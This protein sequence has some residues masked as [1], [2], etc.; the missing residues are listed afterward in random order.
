MKLHPS[1]LAVF[2]GAGVASLAT[3]CSS[4][5]SSTPG[6][7]RGSESASS[8]GS[9]GGATSG[10][11]S[12]SGS[13]SSGGS[14]SGSGS[15]GGSGSSS[16]SVDSGSSDGGSSSGS[17]GSS[18]LHVSGGRIVDGQGN[19]VVLHGANETGSQTNCAY[20]AGG[21][22]SAGYPGFFDMPPT[23][24]AVNQMLAWKINAVRVPLNE[25]C[26]L[27]IN[28]LPSSGSTSSDYQS[29]IE[30]F[31]SLLT[32]SG[33]SVILDLHWAGPGTDQTGPS[34]GQIPMADADHALTF[35]TSVASA[36]KSNGSV[37]FDLYNE[38]GITDWSCWVSGAA[39]SAKCAQASGKSYA[40]AG[41]ATMLQ[42]VRNAGAT[43]IAILGGLSLSQDFSKWVTSVQSIP[44]LPS[45]LD[46]ISTDNVA[47]S[48]HA[49]DFNS[50]YTQCPS[51]YN[52]PA[53]SGQSCA[54]A[55]QFATSSGIADVLSAGFPVVVG[56]LAI[57]AFSTSTASKFSSA[58]LTVLQNWLDGLMTYM[59]GQQQ[60]YLAWSWDLDQTPLMITDYATGA[61]TP[62]FGATYQKHLQSTF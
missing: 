39:A 16:G 53:Y 27:G 24:A 59:E 19:T 42:T 50:V 57:S 29:A 3:G 41:M 40:V 9:G 37:I 43:N 22:A 20:Q 25:D 55:Q 11:S 23:Q 28:G 6:S 14:S 21:S 5:S 45:P 10:G 26:W 18:G 61:P 15:D 36:F 35:W 13:G 34:L 52:Q 48:W 17:G 31:V 33:L 51:Q 46:G 12:G 47:A 8:S 2:L 38:P 60:G 62:Y 56:E 58:Q 30:Q 44:S 4:S 49:Y 1:G 32:T 54:T 7:N